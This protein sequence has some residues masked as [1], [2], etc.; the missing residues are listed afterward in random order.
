MNRHTFV[1]SVTAM[2]ML[3]P[4]VVY[5]QSA[6]TQAASTTASNS[7]PE[8]DKTF[9][10]AASM[11]SSTEIDASKLAATRSDSADVKK[12]AAR[13]VLDHTKLTLQL[14]MAAPKGVVVPNDNSDVEVLNSLKD[15]KGKQFDDAY[16][17]K[18]GVEGHKKALDAFSEEAD[19]GQ[20]ASLKAA[21][22]KA[23][24]VILHH[25]QMAQ[26]LASPAKAT[27]AP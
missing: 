20:N 27:S 22:K 18:V 14:K 16:I 1:A 12:F 6:P 7:L 17:Q 13:M 10:Q 26:A 21:A 5:A 23:L 24:P 15:L 19:S 3:V 8:P 2:W 11:S 9:V 25:C 4:A